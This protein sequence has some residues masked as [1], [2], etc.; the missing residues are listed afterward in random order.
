MYKKI[1][2]LFLRF[3][4]KWVVFRKDLLLCVYLWLFGLRWEFEYV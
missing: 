1:I 4:E 2:F 3:E